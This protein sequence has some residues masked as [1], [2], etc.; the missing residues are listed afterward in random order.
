MASPRD[1]ARQIKGDSNVRLKGDQRVLLSAAFAGAELLAK[2]A[3]KDTGILKSSIRAMATEDGA[4]ILLDAPHAAIVELGSRPHFPP[5]QPLIDW[6]RRQVSRGSIET[7]AK[8]SSK[9]SL[10][11][12]K[13]LAGRKLHG[14]ALAAHRQ[15]VERYEAARANEAKYEEEI[16]AI[17]RAIQRK[18][19]REGTKPTYVV[20]NSIDDLVTLYVRLLAKKERGTLLE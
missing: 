19:G 10:R 3:P 8:P 1:V 18:I 9:R 20:R 13:A 4:R 2:R 12:P 15:Y 11:A 6:V 5:L 16:Q 17:A 14:A 7:S